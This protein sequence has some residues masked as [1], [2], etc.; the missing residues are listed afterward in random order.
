MATP[1][2]SLLRDALA[3]LAPLARAA[4]SAPLADFVAAHA[5]A[6]NA[7]AAAD[8]DSLARRRAAK[9]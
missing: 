2:E 8:G 5:A 3:A 4:A 6:L 1:R 7:F 9:R